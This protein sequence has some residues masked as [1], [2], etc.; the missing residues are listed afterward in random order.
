MRLL[1]IAITYLKQ[2]FSSRSVVIFTI[3][4]P[5]LYTYILAQA[6]KGMDGSNTPAVWSLL[7]ADE[8]RSRASEMLGDR[9]ETVSDLKVIPAVRDEALQK[10]DDGKAA[11]ALVV[12]AGFGETLEGGEGG[13]SLTF[14]QSASNPLNAQ[15][16]EQ[17]VK[18]AA[19]D[20]EAVY[21]MNAMAVQLSNNLG[22]LPD[23]NARASFSRKSLD[24]AEKMWI[25]SAPLKMK[26]IA[27]T[28]MKKAKVP[29]GGAQSSPGM[30]VMF[31]LFLTFGGGTSLLMERERGT[32]RRLM[33]MPIDKFVIVGGKLLGIFIGALA[34]MVLMIL[35]GQYLMGV[36]WGQSPAALIVMMLAYAFA[37]TSLG[38]MIAALVKSSAQADSLNTI[39][40]M[41][42]SAL[43]GAWWPIEIVPGWMR[44]LAHALPTYW[45]M[46]GFQDIVSRGLGLSAVLPESGILML[47]GVGFLLVGL[48]R[49]RFEN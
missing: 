33:V 6:M 40:V 46:Q 35:V 47:F 43:G 26:T 37:A 21:S 22:L 41:A 28:R 4:M 13:A 25:E 10:V 16:L 19:A 20:V 23:E 32:L 30:I 48:W 29:I 14:F 9:L 42:L 18:S 27:V 44:S 3:L 24:E 34:Q 8:D 15:I 11:A 5:L 36:N 38:I 1:T 12:P 2:T 7:M 31:V 45:G 49:F 39:V 17:A